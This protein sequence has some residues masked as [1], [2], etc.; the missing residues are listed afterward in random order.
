MQVQTPHELHQPPAGRQGSPEQHGISN[1]VNDNP[2]D[3]CVAS[4][5]HGNMPFASLNN[6]ADL[7]LPERW[8]LQAED[9]FDIYRARQNGQPVSPGY[10][11]HAGTEYMQWESE[12]KWHL[13]STITSSSS[14]LVSLPTVDATKTGDD[15]RTMGDSTSASVAIST[16]S[17]TASSAVV[18]S[19]TV[20]IA[21]SPKPPFD[22]L[23]WEEVAASSKP[24]V[25]RELYDACDIMS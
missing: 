6:Y 13:A 12:L 15:G 14:G 22:K 20:S 3:V 17:T 9:F 5:V 18:S 24:A 1:D 19:A 11:E 4:P 21:T 7:D 25:S 16:V 8:K 10:I 23:Y 2:A